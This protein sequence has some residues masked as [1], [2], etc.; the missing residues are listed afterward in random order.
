MNTRSSTSKNAPSYSQVAN[1]A[2]TS[3]QVEDDNQ[4]ADS[5]I[6][7]ASADLL[8]VEASGRDAFDLPLDCFETS[9]VADGAN[10]G[11]LSQI[12]TPDS[13]FE[14]PTRANSDDSFDAVN[15][16]DLANEIDLEENQVVPRP[17]PTPSR[18]EEL[19]V[20]DDEKEEESPII[21]LCSAVAEAESCQQSPGMRLAAG[22]SVHSAGYCNKKKIVIRNFIEG[23]RRAAPKY[24]AFLKPPANIP[25][26]FSYAPSEAVFVLLSPFEKDKQKKTKMLNEMLIDWVNGMVKTHTRKKKRPPRT[27]TPLAL[28]VPLSGVFW[29]RPRSSLGGNFL[30]LI[31]SSLGDSMPFSSS[32]LRTGGK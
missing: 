32:S 13:S 15:G 2:I 22:S 30:F 16:I 1:P 3:Y 14:E 17:V 18:Q 7:E 4:A 31:S 27:G 11:G 28:S 9:P 12:V 5:L 21:D 10:E 24:N 19:Q 29:Q 8:I 23:L 6:V 26:W 20:E 25:E